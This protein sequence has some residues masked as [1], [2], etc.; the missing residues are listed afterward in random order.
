MPEAM[1]KEAADRIVD[2]LSKVAELVNDGATPNE[3]IEKAARQADIP[4]GHIPLLVNAYNIGRS[5]RQREDNDDPA[6]KAAD[7]ALADTSEILDRIFPPD[8]EKAAAATRPDPVD[9]VYL[10]SPESFLA[11][12]QLRRKMAEAPRT[13]RLVDQPPPPLPRS[14][15]RALAKAAA[16]ERRLAYARDE[17]RRRASSL[18]MDLRGVFEKLAEDF[19]TGGNLTVADVRENVGIL[20][21][22]AGL[23][24]LD[25]VVRMRP[26][27]AKQASAPPRRHRA[28]REPVYGQIKRALDL[29]GELFEAREAHRVFEKLARPTPPAAPAR[30]SILDR[31]EKKADPGGLGDKVVGGL[32]YNLMSDIY[33]GWKP[34]DPDEMVKK[35]LGRLTTPSH[36][37]AMREIQMQALMHEMLSDDEVLRGHDPHEVSRAYNRISQLVPASAG[38]PAVVI[39]AVRKALAQGGMDSFDAKELADTHHKLQAPQRPQG[40]PNA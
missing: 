16:D 13:I 14:N 35:Q 33:G 8:L 3:A 18:E 20:H 25:H 37:D 11:A 9:P 1:S 30:P 17:A 15:E 40:A 7:F 39:P 23:A 2:A 21:G 5:T 31:M 24:V 6:E 38:Q 4:A 32:T 26:S 29:A 28:D 36:Q 27:L 10:S 19:R 34:P 22:D 12:R